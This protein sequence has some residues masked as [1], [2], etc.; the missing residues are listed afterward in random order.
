MPPLQPSTMGGA[1]AAAMNGGGLLHQPTSYF[2]QPILH[3][4]EWILFF[5]LKSHGAF[6]LGENEEK[7]LG[8]SLFFFSLFPLHPPFFCVGGSGCRFG[9]W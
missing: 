4:G 6:K 8:I 7:I 1:A 5:L 9:I 3:N 2:A